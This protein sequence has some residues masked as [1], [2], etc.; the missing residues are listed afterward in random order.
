LSRSL[1]IA[2]AARQ[3]AVGWGQRLAWVLPPVIPPDCEELADIIKRVRRHTMTPPRRIA[4]LCDA[5]SYVVRNQIP[6]AVAECGVWRGG[7]MM[8]AALMLMRLDAVDRDIYLFDTFRGMPPPS[9][10]DTPSAYDGYSPM[11]HWRRR[12]RDEINSW[13][14]ASA[15]S[16]REAMLST[17]YPAERIHLV[18]G[19]IER[20]LP[21]HAPEHIALLR[22][23][24]D[25]YEPIRHAMVH[26]YPR[27]CAG[28]VLIIDDYGHYEGA[29]R[30]VEEFFAQTGERP[31]LTRVDYTCRVA[32]RRSPA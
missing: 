15:N 26:L 3:F 6:G 25:W 4:A 5:V 22:L 10:A 28:G 19:R 24:T 7:S 20:T 32:V 1:E 14:Y 18:E 31:L 16:V 12:Q 8:A 2:H 29:R 13:H 21:E 9:G 23:D 27:V 17:G 11:R 30:A